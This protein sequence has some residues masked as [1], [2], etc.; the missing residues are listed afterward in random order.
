MKQLDTPHSTKRVQSFSICLSDTPHLSPVTYVT[1]T[2]ETNLC[3]DTMPLSILKILNDYYL[4]E[5][6]STVRLQG[7]SIRLSDTS[8]PVPSNY[9]I[10]TLEINLCLITMP[11]SIKSS[12]III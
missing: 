10:R 9:V 7:F 4:G 11:L 3:L 6:Y 5:K 12:I 1:R 2:L 8:T